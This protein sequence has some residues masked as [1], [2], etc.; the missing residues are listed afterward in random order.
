MG[1][2]GSLYIGVSGLQT[3]QNALNTTAHNLANVGTAGYVRQ[4]VIQSDTLY[5]KIRNGAI[6]SQQVGLGSTLAQV[7][8][9]RDRFLDQTY[10][11]ESGRASFYDVGYS[12][13]YEMESILG[14]LKGEEFSDSLDKLNDA[15]SELSKVPSDTDK[16]TLLKQR[17][18]EFIEDAQNVYSL[19][20]GYQYNLNDQVVDTIDTINN[21]AQ[22]IG[23]LN[24][25]ISKVESGN[26]E[27]ANDLRDARN[28]V[29]DQLAGLIKISYSED[30]NG[31]VTVQAEG[32]P[33]VGETSVYEMGYTTDADTGFVTPTWSDFNNQKVYNMKLEISTEKDTDVGKLKALLLQRGTETTNYS[34]IPVKEKYQD[35]SGNWAT[36]SWTI[37]GTTYTDGDKAYSAATDYYN[38]NIALSGMMNTMAEFDQLIHGIVTAINDVLSP[39]TS[40]TVAPAETWTDADGNTLTVGDTYTVLDLDHCGQSVDGVKGTEL[41]SRSATERYTRYTYTDGGG[42]VHECY[43]YN[44]EDVTKK[45]SMYSIENLS[46]NS[47]VIDNAGVLP[48]YT[49]N[50]TV[51]YAKGEAL[52]ALWEEKFAALNPNSTAKVTFQ[53]Y[54]ASFLVDDVGNT[55]SVYKFISNAENAT[56][57]SFDNDRQMVI[58]VSSDEELSNMIRFQNAYNA[59]SRYINVVSEMLEHI[60]TTLGNS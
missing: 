46:V 53:D 40:M 17:A 7:R 5:N 9:V 33:L 56:A 57:A 26:V 55:A 42:T 31:V 38:T 20:K 48:L 13:Y 29:L 27:N 50:G 16:Q 2:M 14:S 52:Y 39:N 44:E 45:N 51:D 24:K 12:T 4:Q 58:G 34:S 47:E 19:M 10:R 28:M 54:Y 15:F 60:V 32:V 1:G 3:S 37:D 6:S 49:S 36:G 43:V 8:Q 35:S 21:L 30:S 18:V 25:K 22:T 11:M 23:D 41:F 59:S